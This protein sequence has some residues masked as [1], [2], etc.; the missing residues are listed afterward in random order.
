MTPPPSLARTLTHCTSIPAEAE[1]T[2]A[3]LGRNAPGAVIYAA[4]KTAAEKAFWA[5]RDERKPSFAM[6]ALN[7]VY[8]IFLLLPTRS[9]IFF[10]RFVAGPPLVTPKTPSAISETILP[11]WTIF[12]GGA[13]P[14]FPTPGLGPNVDV[15]DVAYLVSYSLSHAQETDGERY[16]ASGSFSSSQAIADVLRKAFPD[17]AG[18]IVEG[19]PGQGYRSD[20]TPDETQLT[21]ESRKAKALMEG[22]NWIPYEKMVV[23]TAKAFQGLV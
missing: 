10:D 17:A 20:Y 11:I 13:H 15:R 4:S 5:F 12:S 6:T 18:R 1:A 14:T 2:V 23:D 3:E 19:M 9:N 22:G 21:V 7:P 16:I 8:A